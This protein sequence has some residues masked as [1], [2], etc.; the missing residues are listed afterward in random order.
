MKI[1]LLQIKDWMNFNH[2]KTLQYLMFKFNI[3]ILYLL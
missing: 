1:N 3:K 2:I